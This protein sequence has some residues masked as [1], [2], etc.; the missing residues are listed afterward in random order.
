MSFSL[1]S[2]TICAQNLLQLERNILT[3][4]ELIILKLYLTVLELH[5]LMTGSYVMFILERRCS[6]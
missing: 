2:L 1:I 3:K 6:R 4:K 5:F